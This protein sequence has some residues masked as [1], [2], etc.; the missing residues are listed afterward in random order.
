M[1]KIDFKKELKNLYSAPSKGPVMVDVPELNFLM[2]DGSG[3]PNTSVEYREAMGA[4]YSVAYGLKFAVKK[5]K[6]E[7]D[8]AVMPLE[9]LWRS[10]DPA[11]FTMGRKDKWQWTAMIMQPQYVTAELFRDVLAQTEKK[12]PSP[13]LAKLRLEAFREGLSAQ[14]MYTGPYSAEGPTIEK[15]HSFIKEKGYSLAGKHHEI[16]FGNP[17]RTAPDKLKTMIRQPAA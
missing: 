2:I 12:K 3:D 13:G 11:D 6:D 10:K 14:V 15:V 1:T 7:I 5:G 17:E 16:Y 9:G 8:F 4:L